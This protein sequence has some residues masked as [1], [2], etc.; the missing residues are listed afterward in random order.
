[1]KSYSVIGKFQNFKYSVFNFIKTNQIKLIIIGVI[2]LI[3]FVT[4]I[5]T[6]IKFA[7]GSITIVYSDFGIKEFANGSIGTTQMFFQRLLSYSVILLILT[8]CSLTVVLFPIGV[9]AIVYRGFLLGL[10]ITFIIV[11]YGVSGI[12]ITAILIIFPLQILML[13]L[14]VLFFVMAR[15]HCIVKGKYGTKNEI[16]IFLLMLIFILLFSL[17]NLAETILLVISSAKVI[18]II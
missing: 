8:V 14:M 9:V 12:I 16:N 4:G 15:N 5:F 6:A 2:T 13:I 1:M 3:A 18:L 17:I 10:N 7:N 11:I